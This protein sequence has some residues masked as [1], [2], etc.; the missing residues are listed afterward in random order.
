MPREAVI[1][2]P[3][4]CGKTTAGV[5]LCKGWLKEDRVNPSTV[6][7][8]AFTKAA[9]NEA[10]SR[11]LDEDVREEALPYFRTIHSLA[12]RGLKKER[13]DVR[14]LTPSDM[15][16]FATWSGMDGAYAVSAWEDLADVYRQMDNRGRTDW[17]QCQTAYAL[18]RMT[19]RTPGE[20]SAAQVR[21]GDLACRMMGFLETAVYETWVR[22]YEAFKKS[23]GLVD[24]TDMLAYALTTMKPIDEVKYVV[25]DEFQDNSRLLEAIT[26]KLF[27]NADAIYYSADEDQCLFSFAGADPSIF[28]EKVRKADVRIFLRQTHRFGQEIVDLSQRIIHRVKNRVEKE[29]LGVAGRNHEIRMTGSFKPRMGPIL[30]LHRHVAGCQAL[31]QAYITAGLPFRNERG[32]NPLGAPGR[33]KGFL[34]IQDLADGTPVSISAA[35]QLVE[36]L[37]PSTIVT[38]EQG[39]VRLVVHGGKKKLQDMAGR[40]PM[41][42][43]DLIQAKILT[44]EGADLVRMK[45]YHAL[46]Y[47]NDLEYYA[48]VIG[49]GYKLDGD[50][51]TITTIHGSKG[52]QAEEVVVFTEMGRKC[53]EDPDTE[54]RLAFVAATRTKGSLEFCAER[55]VE[56]AEN[57]YDYPVEGERHG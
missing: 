39:K 19:C 9:A 35:A 2:G 1:I 14:V 20:L 8:L 55:T 21:F 17:D 12:Y 54:H 23:N 47:T 40:E 5:T 57:S 49:N 7:Y 15:K 37:I 41:R 22:Q 52:R 34:S 24:F 45:R 48:R 27:R 56:W 30:I 11:I 50:L 13:S 32:R 26:S 33:I 51:P 31:A 18:T 53:W 43:Q 16:A 46:K 36:D 28:I 6:A 10:A 44:S 3:P 25:I 38:P 4:G 42:L 29:L